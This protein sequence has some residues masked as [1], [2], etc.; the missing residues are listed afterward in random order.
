V[1]S[2]YRTLLMLFGI[3]QPALFVVLAAV[4]GLGIHRLWRRD[5]DL[6]AYLAAVMLGAAL[7]I[8]VAR[9]QW[10]HHPAVYARYLLPA[11]PFLLLFL[12]EGALACLAPLRRP[13]A[14]AP[15]AVALAALLWW[16]G[17]MP[18]YLYRPNQFIGHL[19]FQYDYDPAHNPYVQE[20]PRDPIPAFY[21]ELAQKPPR[22]L[23][24][25]EAPW[26]LESNFNPHPWYQEV[27]RCT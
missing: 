16:S 15:V 3:A 18:D 1:E 19:R 23:T 5:R 13:V 17:P 20:T 14:Q 12:A 27:H 21:R 26:R 8:A 22:T 2:I 11:L 24:L 9:P 25:I 10:I 6:T 4:T 7:A